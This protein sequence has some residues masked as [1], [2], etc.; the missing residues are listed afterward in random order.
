MGKMAVLKEVKNNAKVRAK[1]PNWTSENPDVII[2]D[3]N[4]GKPREIT[5][6]NVE[7]CKADLERDNAAVVEIREY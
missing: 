4:N 1:L 3:V 5:D 2:K 6:F 7:A